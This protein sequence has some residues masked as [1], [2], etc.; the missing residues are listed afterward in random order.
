MADVIDGRAVVQAADVNER[1]D[2]SSRVL[3][4]EVRAVAVH[5]GPTHGTQAVGGI[6]AGVVIDDASEQEGDVVLSH[7]CSAA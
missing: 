1:L 5:E 4:A 2:E 3:A 7:W 6:G